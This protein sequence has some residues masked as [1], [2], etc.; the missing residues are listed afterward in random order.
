MEG[1]EQKLINTSVIFIIKDDIP[2]VGPGI[3]FDN[4]HV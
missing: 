4:D 1:K 2:Q 3:E